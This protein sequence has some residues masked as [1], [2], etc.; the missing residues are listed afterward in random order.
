MLPLD[1]NLTKKGIS[2]S[3]DSKGIAEEE[4]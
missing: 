1:T 3:I 4:D 2:A